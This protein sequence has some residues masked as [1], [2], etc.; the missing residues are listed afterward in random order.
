M[1]SFSPVSVLLFWDLFKAVKQCKTMETIGGKTYMCET[2]SY[3]KRSNNS[4]NFWTKNK[5]GERST[6]QQLL[7]E[8]ATSQN[9]HIDKKKTPLLNGQELCRPWRLCLGL[10]DCFFPFNFFDATAGFKGMF[11]NKKH[12][13]LYMLNF[14]HSTPL[15]RD[16]YSGQLCEVYWWAAGWKGDDLSSKLRTSIAYLSST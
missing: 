14:N 11:F 16:L 15:S 7:S 5:M 6:W 1:I 8:S 12:S 9:V 4:I 2:H 10:K 3:P 13:D